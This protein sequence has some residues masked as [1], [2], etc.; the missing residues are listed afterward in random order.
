MKLL[1]DQNL[2]PRLAGLLA[3]VYPGVAHVYQFNL[4]KSPDAAVLAFAEKT[5]FIL[6][7]KDADFSDPHRISHHAVKVVWIRRGNCSTRDVADILRRHVS[8]LAR[9][10]ELGRSVCFDSILTNRQK[11][12]LTARVGSF[13][14]LGST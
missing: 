8:N 9:L 12:S 2:S 1:L 11:Q 6:V 13:T 14:I 7:S 5:G 3:D 4:D 10:H